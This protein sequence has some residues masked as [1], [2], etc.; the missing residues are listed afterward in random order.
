MESVTPSQQLQGLVVNCG[1]ELFQ[2]YDIDVSA[3]PHYQLPENESVLS[4]IIGFSGDSLQGTLVL[5]ASQTLLESSAFGN[6]SA[7]DWIGE[8]ANQLLGRIKNQLLGFGITIYLSTPVMMRGENLDPSYR[9]PGVK[10][11]YLCGSSDGAVI[12]F[13]FEPSEGVELVPVNGTDAP[14]QKEGELLL[15]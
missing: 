9:H 8:L 3:A 6:T 7:E 4:G 12:W 5:C 10:P 11:I 1:I 14:S 2:A 13:D 15:F